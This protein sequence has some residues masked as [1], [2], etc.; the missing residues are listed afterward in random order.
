MINFWQ[1]QDSRVIGGNSFILRFAF[2]D[3]CFLGDGHL[4]CFSLTIKHWTG[5]FYGLL[6]DSQS[7]Y[8]LSCSW[9][10]FIVLA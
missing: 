2:L 10:A 6:R 8:F 3:T 7:C 9:V 1:L 5:C 4:E